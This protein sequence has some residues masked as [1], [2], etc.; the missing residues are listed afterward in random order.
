MD[1]FTFFTELFATQD[2]ENSASTSTSQWQEGP[3]GSSEVPAFADSE[4]YGS[5]TLTA[6]CVIS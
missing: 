6:F 2:V 4:R 5:G 3:E 1:S